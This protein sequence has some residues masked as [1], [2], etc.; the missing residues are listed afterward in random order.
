MIVSPSRALFDTFPG[1]LGAGKRI[2]LDV[3]FL[4]Y[5]LKMCEEKPPLSHVLWFIGISMLVILII[6]AIRAWYKHLYCPKADFRTKGQMDHKMFEKAMSVDLACYEN[7]AYYDRFQRVQSDYFN[8]NMGIYRTTRDL[9]VSVIENVTVIVLMATVDPLALMF[10]VTPFL[11]VFFLSKRSKK[12]RVDLNQANTAPARRAAYSERTIYMKEYA[13]EM[14]L[15]RIYEPIIRNYTEAVEKLKQNIRGAGHRIAVVD[16]FRCVLSDNIMY[17]G[18]LIYILLRVLLI[19]GGDNSASDWLLLI[20][21]IASF[22]YTLQSIADRIQ[23]LSTQ[24]A[25]IDLYD[26]YFS[27]E[28]AISEDGK[29]K[30]VQTSESGHIIRFEHVTFTYPGQSKLTIND[31]NLTIN[32]KQKIGIVGINGAGKSTIL[33]LLLRLYDPDSGRITCDGVDIREYTVREYRALFGT[34]LQDVK[35]FSLS[36]TENVVAGSSIKG[37]DERAEEALQ[38]SSFGSKLSSIPDGVHSV[39]TKEFDDH[40]VILSGGEAQKIAIARAHATNSRI[41]LLDE[42]SSALDPMAEHE[43]IE[44]MYAAC[45]DKSMVLISHRLSNVVPADCIYVIDNGQAV[46]HGTH[47]ELMTLNGIYAELFRMQA[48]GYQYEEE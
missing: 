16:F 28:P 23:S 18:L 4:A 34:V 9:L 5:L 47:H 40:G 15:F 22:T 35:L 38:K 41:V 31:L 29:G 10:G 33:K 21:S 42:P 17:F 8:V 25:Q 45:A 11:L 39:L 36:I 46:E 12:L 6:E 20:N 32:S 48:E 43:M 3:I 19:G 26:E 14:R 30:S 13:K 7:P 27:Y 2:F 24:A 37:D 1:L 44:T